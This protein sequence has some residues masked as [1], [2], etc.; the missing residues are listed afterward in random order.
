MAVPLATPGEI[1]SRPQI[2]AHDW[3]AGIIGTDNVGFV[4][5][6]FVHIV[7]RTNQLQ[8][9]ATLLSRAGEVINVVS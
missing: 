9:S 3:S 8:Y 6:G 5:V 4:H 7:A 1:R 2:L